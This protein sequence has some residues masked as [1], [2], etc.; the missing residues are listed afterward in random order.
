MARNSRFPKTTDD[1]RRGGCEG[2][3][4]IYG[5]VAFVCLKREGGLMYC[6]RKQHN[7]P[8]GDLVNLLLEAIV[9]HKVFVP[10]LN[11]R[12]VLNLHGCRPPGLGLF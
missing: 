4:F 3:E 12:L 11:E 2:R 1:R 8:M 7:M 10:L 5:G 9:G 6:G